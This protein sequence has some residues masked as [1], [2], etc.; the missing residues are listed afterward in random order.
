MG[1]TGVFCLS[2][3]GLGLLAPEHT[4]AL[5]RP[6]GLYV[7]LCI[8]G[9]VVVVPTV[10]AIRGSTLWIPVAVLGAAT[11]VTFFIRGDA[12]ISSAS[13]NS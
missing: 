6:Y 9:A 1:T 5:L 3:F 13:R 8:L 4:G 11:L 7:W 2:A 10:A 12:V